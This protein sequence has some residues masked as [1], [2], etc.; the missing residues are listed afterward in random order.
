M[1]SRSTQQLGQRL[2][3]FRGSD[4]SLMHLGIIQI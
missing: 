4:A 3:V 2:T 1:D